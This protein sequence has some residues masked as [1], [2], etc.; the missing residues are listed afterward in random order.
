MRLSRDALTTEIIVHECVHAAAAI[1]RMDVNTV[2]QLGD[3]CNPQEE[4][5][6]YIVGDLTKSVVNALHGAGAWQ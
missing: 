2:M 4:T 1:Y 6:A 5:L 3:A